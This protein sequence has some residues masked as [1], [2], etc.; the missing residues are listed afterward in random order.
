MPAL[1][2]SSNHLRWRSSHCLPMRGCMI[3]I[4]RRVVKSLCKRAGA[5]RF[6]PGVA[7]SKQTRRRLSRSDDAP[8]A[9]PQHDD[10]PRP[11]VLSR[12]KNMFYVSYISSA[13]PPAPPS[14]HGAPGRPPR[15]LPQPLHEHTTALVVAEALSVV[16]EL[17]ST[18]LAPS[19]RDAHP[20][21]LLAHTDAISRSIRGARRPA[22]PGVFGP[23]LVLRRGR[24]RAGSYRLSRLL[25]AGGHIANGRN[26]CVDRLAATQFRKAF[27]RRLP[28]TL[29]PSR[30]GP[31][32]P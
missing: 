25:A 4:D 12:I 6:L 15:P 13:S 11:R 19:H 26:I 16:R 31:A 27:T 9:I 7:I 5:C 20:K 24:G 18:H 30:C 21:P 23:R 17:F 10:G 22:L 2:R 28:P 3:G 14:G 29:G 32:S 8:T 1:P